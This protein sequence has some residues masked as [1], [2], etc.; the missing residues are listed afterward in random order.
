MFNIPTPRV[1]QFFSYYDLDDGVRANYRARLQSQADVPLRDALREYD[2]VCSGN[3]SNMLRVYG[4]TVSLVGKVVGL[5]VLFNRV[6]AQSKELA[7]CRRF[8]LAYWACRVVSTADEVSMLS[9]TQLIVR[10]EKAV[11]ECRRAGVPVSG[12]GMAEIVELMFCGDACEH[13]LAASQ[14]SE[15]SEVVK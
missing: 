2:A 13:W 12:R 1:D 15:L 8:D 14:A 9:P 3:A 6:P 10:T 7:F 5:D 11:E 4:F